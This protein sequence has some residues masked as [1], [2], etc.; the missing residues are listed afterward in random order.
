MSLFRAKATMNNLIES[1]GE[2]SISK[3][4]LKAGYPETTAHNPQQLTRSKTWKRLLDELLPEDELIDKLTENI[5][6]KKSINASNAA[7]DMAFKL[8]GKYQKDKENEESQNK[9]LDEL[10]NENQEL[11]NAIAK[12]KL[13][14]QP[15]N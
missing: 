15:R 9:T 4:M 3:A 1:K 12:R 14:A 11:K 2:L 13:Q 6:Q 10:E 7:L 8:R 5:K